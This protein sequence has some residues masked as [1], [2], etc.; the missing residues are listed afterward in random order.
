[1]KRNVWFWTFGLLLMLSGLVL[2]CLWVL[3]PPSSGSY[4]ILLWL[5]ML[6]GIIY[7]IITGY[8]AVIRSKPVNLSL[9]IL[10]LL[11]VL[12]FAAIA[13]L[14]ACLPFPP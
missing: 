2:D 1:M 3:S 14:G 12:I 4:G 7:L 5:N 13:N 9:S 11:P 8:Y 6:P 10:I